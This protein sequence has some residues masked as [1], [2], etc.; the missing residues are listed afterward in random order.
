VPKNGI[1]IGGYH[2]AGGV[3]QEI[4]KLSLENI[5][6]IDVRQSFPWSIQW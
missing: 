5:D 3:S 2:I 1:D 4:V 6:S